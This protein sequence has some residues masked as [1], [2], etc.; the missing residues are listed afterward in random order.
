MG[1]YV[2]ESFGLSDCQVGEDFAV[3][4][5]FGFFEGGDKYRVFDAQR[6]ESG[7]EADD[8]GAAHIPGAFVAAGEGI[9]TGMENRFFGRFVQPVFGQAIAFGRFQDF[10]MSLASG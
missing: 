9:L 10:I 6:V 4:I 3:K 1:N 5:N 8:P 2:L 7:V